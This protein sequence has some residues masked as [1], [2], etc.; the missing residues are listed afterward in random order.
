MRRSAVP[1]A[2]A[3]VLLLMPLGVVDPALGQCTDCDGDGIALPAD[4]NDADPRNYPGNLEVC[5]GRDNNCNGQIDDDPSCVNFCAAPDRFGQEVRLSSKGWCNTTTQRCVRGRVGATCTSDAACGSGASE[6][7]LVWTGAG[8]GTTWQQDEAGVALTQ[9]LMFAGF[10]SGG[11]GASLTAQLTSG[12][13]SQVPSIVW[14]GS[15]FGVSWYDPTGGSSEIYF[16]RVLPSGSFPPGLCDTGSG[17]CTQGKV[18]ATCTQNADCTGGLRVTDNP[19]FSYAPSLAWNGQEYG[20]AW[21]DARD[22]N[23]EIYFA[24]ISAAGGKIGGDIRVTSAP[25]HSTSPSLVWADQG[26]GLA[27]VDERDQ[28][29]G[30]PL[31]EIYFAR[32]DPAGTKI[33]SDLRVTSSAAFSSAPSLAWSGTEYGVAWQDTRDGAMEIYFAGI[34]AAGSSTLGSNVRVTNDPAFSSAPSLVWTG[35][36]FGLAWQDNRSGSNEIFYTRITQAGAKTGSDIRLTQNPNPSLSNR[37]AINPS[38]VWTGQEFGLLWQDKRS[39]D[40]ES[41]FALLRCDCTQNVDGDSATSCSDCR[42]DL[43]GVF[44]GAVDACDGVDT[45]CDSPAAPNPDN[46]LEI[47]ADGDK[48]LPCTGFVDNN[49]GLLGGNDCAVNDGN[50]FPGAVELCD[51]DSNACLATIPANEIDQDGDKYVACTGW[52]DSQGNN[53]PAIS[54]GGDCY[55]LS[56]TGVCSTNGVCGTASPRVCTV[57]R[58]GVSCSNNSQC[59]LCTAGRIGVACTTNA[60]CNTTEFTDSTRTFPGAAPNESSPAACI[61]DTDND[62]WGDRNPLAGITPGTDCNDG[63]AQQ[64][65]G[66]TWYPDCDGDPLGP[67]AAGRFAQAGRGVTACDP[68]EADTLTNCADGMPPDGGWRSTPGND[69]DDED[70]TEFPG[71]DWFPDCDADGVFLFLASSVQ[72]CDVAAADARAITDMICADGAP[73]DGGWTHT[74]PPVGSRD[75][76]DNDPAR[77]PGAVEICGNGID[78]DCD[79]LADDAPTGVCDTGTGI[80]TAGN[81]GASCSANSDCDLCVTAV[82]ISAPQEVA[83]ISVNGTSVAWQMMP[84]VPTYHVYRGDVSVLRDQGIYTQ[85]PQLDP[86]AARMCGTQTSPEDDQFVPPI[87]KVVFYLV[88]ADNGVLEGPLGTNGA[89]VPRPNTNPCR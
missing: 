9:E 59:N 73:P 80:C 62:N 82:P 1:L 3:V 54:G 72:A 11:A 64:F 79:G 2:V 29:G 19:A 15:E 10:A 85:D 5:D 71:Q 35:S 68:A 39:L 77:L 51:G 44:P 20:L 52:S 7:D 55:D 12:T 42:D 48:Y 24:R 87:G 14:T 75:C 57:G 61:K 41:Y 43:A 8:F 76:D 26:Y 63:D 58:V 53:T 86:N 17:L 23:R 84:S 45:N 30:P 32:L 50:T 31:R 69:C 60:A 22:G 70:P 34:D 36:E 25:G 6:P 4:C 83:Q 21:Y 78:E 88:T 65:P 49:V 18:G 46:P 40:W 81:T 66:Q 56:P 38:L 74:P 67:G 27:W 89:G 28:M 33:G 13:D 47:D 37:N 16:S